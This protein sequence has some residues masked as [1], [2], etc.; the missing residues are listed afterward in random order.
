MIHHR[1]LG[2]RPAHRHRFGIAQ[3]AGLRFAAPL[4]AHPQRQQLPGLR[5]LLA[6]ERRGRPAPRPPH[7]LNGQRRHRE[8]DRD[9]ARH[10]RGLVPAP[11]KQ[12]RGDQPKQARETE[13]AGHGPDPPGVA[14]IDRHERHRARTRA[15]KA[16]NGA[17][18][19]AVAL[20]SRSAQPAARR[21]E[22]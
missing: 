7:Q 13:Q 12:Q 6:G 3:Q 20:G 18:T 5:H 22:A 17:R 10:L 19:V 1:V 9:H 16:T 8:D 15:P 11:E 4:L 21:P 2:Q 14:A